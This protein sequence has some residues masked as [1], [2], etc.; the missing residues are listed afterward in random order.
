MPFHLLHYSRTP[1][2]NFKTMIVGGPNTRSD[3]HINQTEEWFYQ[4]QGS[5]VLRVVDQGVFKDIPIHEGEH[6][7]LPGNTPHSPQRFSNTIGLVMEIERPGSLEDGLRWYCPN[8]ECRQITHEVLFKCES[9]VKQLPLVINEY[10]ARED[11]RT[12][13]G[14]GL[15]DVKP[16]TPVDIPT[17]PVV[18]GGQHATHNGVLGTPAHPYPQSLRQWLSV[19]EPAR[20]QAKRMVVDKLDHR[21]PHSD[22]EPGE[23]WVYVVDGEVTVTFGEHSA[24]LR[25]SD[26]VLIPPH[27]P[28]SIHTHTHSHALSVTQLIKDVE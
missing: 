25:E 16:T 18:R 12:C 10:Y 21:T 23:R 1:D 22:G 5:M 28:H 3:Y 2:S 11:L 14:C 6:F 20:L 17:V 27:V 8:P 4:I 13:G 24:V 15:V 7:L 19:D 26:C 9:L